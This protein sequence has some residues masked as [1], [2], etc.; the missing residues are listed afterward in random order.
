LNKNSTET[1]EELA[2]TLNV[3]KST[4]SDHLHAIE[5]IQKE[6]K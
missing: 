1:L 5:R 4:V 3:S 2:K 6:D